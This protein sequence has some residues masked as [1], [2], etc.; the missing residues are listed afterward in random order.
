MSKA[1]FFDIDGTLYDF[2]G[3]MPASTKR[4][5]MLAHANGHKLVLC[6][7]RAKY[8]I[9]RSLLALFDGVIGAAG[10]YVETPEGVLFEQCVSGN[11]IE[12]IVETTGRAGAKLAGMTK[13]H[14]VLNEECRNYLIGQ[15]EQAGMDAARIYQ[16]MGEYEIATHFE[17]RNDIQKFLYFDSKW[18][19]TRLARELEETCDVVSSSLEANALTDGEITMRAVNKSSGIKKYIDNYNIRVEDTYAFG[20]GPNDLDMLQFAGTGIAMGNARQEVKQCADYITKNI[21]EDGI[22]FAMQHFGLI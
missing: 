16:I 5:L 10:A 21:L 11:V 19:V 20:D 8:Q 12:Q 14:L 22:E 9:Y 2:S 3:Q 18:S 15:F 7:G 1:L 17:A 6:T 13:N 4:A